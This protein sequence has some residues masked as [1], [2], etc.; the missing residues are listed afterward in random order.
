MCN[1][2]ACGDTHI[3]SMDDQYVTSPFYPNHYDQMQNCTWHIYALD[4]NSPTDF[5][6]VDLAFENSKNGT[7]DEGLEIY[8]DDSPLP[9]VCD[10][11]SFN[12][13]IL[14]HQTVRIMLRSSDKMKERRFKAV[15]R[16][17]KIGI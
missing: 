8:V 13:S 6:L 3:A 10:D 5:Q 12:S 16:A 15:F 9:R 1:V 2:L 7:C 4:D 14:A 17:G 11:N